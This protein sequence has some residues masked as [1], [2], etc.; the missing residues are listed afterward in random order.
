MVRP[1]AV[2]G[3]SYSAA[4]AAALFI[5]NNEP[6]LP[7]I[8]FLFL[9]AAGFV[10]APLRRTVYFPAIF[11]SALAAMIT[12]MIFNAAFV[13]G[14]DVLME[15]KAEV[16]G[17]ICELPYERNGRVYYKLETS[18]IK[19]PDCR[20]N[21]KILVSSPKALRA[22]VYDTITAKVKFYSK[23]GSDRNPDIARSNY[24]RG[25]LDVYSGVKIT[26]NDSKPP[27]YYALMLRKLI[28]DSINS[29]FTKDDAALITAVFIGDKTGLPYEDTAIFRTA[30]ISHI[31]VASGFHLAVLTGL[32]S[33]LLMFLFRIRKNTASL[34]CIAL[35]FIYMAAV[36]FTPSILRAGIMMIIYLLGQFLFRQTDAINSLGAA[37]LMICFMN[38]YS[39]CDAGFLLSVFSVLGIVLLSDRM[40]DK[41]MERFTV[42]SDDKPHNRMLLFFSDHKKGIRFLISLV[43]IPLSAMVFTF[44]IIIVIFRS[45][46][47]YQ[48]LT[49]I[50]VYV[51]ASLLL[52]ISFILVIADISVIF[53]FLKLPLIL[54]CSALAR[55]IVS[56][57]SFTS[58]LPFAGIK[59]SGEY[60]PIVLMLSIGAAAAY[61]FIR[62]KHGRK[63]VFVFVCSCA[64][65]FMLGNTADI[66]LKAG[67]TKL[68]IL[69]TGN[70]V[71]AILSGNNETAVLYCGGDNDK[72]SEI[73]TYLD[74]I[75]ADEL[76][77]M[78]ITDKTSGAAAFAENVLSSHHAKAIQVYNEEKLTERLHSRVMLSDKVI[79]SDKNQPAI[80]IY[81]CCGTDIYIYRTEKTNALSFKARDKQFLILCGDNDAA[82]LPASFTECDYLVINGKLASPEIIKTENI[83][84][85]DSPSKA[86]DDIESL[87]E[88]SSRLYYTA[89]RGS[90]GIRMYPGGST[91]IR[92]ESSWLN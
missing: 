62:H 57:A 68:S 87:G 38:P 43:T 73:N 89:G 33:V 88:Y 23:T 90:I 34:I 58:A 53:R 49:N 15:N 39:V 28:I 3:F 45:F 47:L 84:V 51:P 25:S 59:T 16:T 20:Q 19:F 24:L 76:S 74:D 14:T 44:P 1:L 18:E 60:V 31:I 70:G 92:R 13:S 30:G 42:V 52:F 48:I 32:I 17:T 78:L 82:L 61:H 54:L 67:S 11:T 80:S 85:S 63:T 65:L 83:I 55:F 41:V 69:D 7:A 71:S 64:L 46:A 91:D 4:L 40:A 77:F 50:I 29:N 75:S 81:S 35:V 56:A 66:I 2:I 36:G 8:V 27:Y 37:V 86:Q 5:L 72:I 79:L 6:L 21:T 12:L 10:I 9:A 26:H 22:E